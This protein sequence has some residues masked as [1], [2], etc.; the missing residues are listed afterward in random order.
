MSSTDSRHFLPDD[1]DDD[2]RAEETGNPLLTSLS[3]DEAVP[4]AN[5]PGEGEGMEVHSGSK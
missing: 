2:E 3:E 4:G 1:D 5:G